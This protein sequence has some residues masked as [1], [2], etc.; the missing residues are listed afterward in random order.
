MYFWVFNFF[1]F[2]W[3]SDWAQPLTA[4]G[5]WRLFLGSSLWV[6]DGQSKRGQSEL[7]RTLKRNKAKMLSVKSASNTNRS[8]ICREAR[9]DA[10]INQWVRLHDDLLSGLITTKYYPIQNFSSFDLNYHSN[11]SLIWYLTTSFCICIK[12]D[13]F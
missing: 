6:A 3:C 8:T 7:T 2:W 12:K 5:A 4:T 9:S 11:M 1:M 13:W 10:V